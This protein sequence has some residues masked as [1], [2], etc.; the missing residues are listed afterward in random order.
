MEVSAQDVSSLRKK[1]GAGIMDCKES[2][3]EAGG[4]FEQAI[5]FLRKKGKKVSVDRF[6][7]DT[8]EGAVFACVNED[9]TESFLVVLSCETDFVAKNSLFLQLGTAILQI[10]ATHKPA[11][12]DELQVLSLGN[13]TVQEDIISSMGTVG[14]KISVSSYEILKGEVV[15]S[16]IHSGNRLGVLVALKGAN[17]ENVLAAGR[18]VAM[19][20]AAM[21]PVALDK[22][23]MDKGVIEREITFIKEKVMAEGHSEDKVDKI[24]QGRLSKFFQENTLLEQLFVKNN[25]LTM[26]QY[27]KK[28]SPSLTVT[29]F[30]RI[31]V[32]E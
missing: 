19:H 1:T 13:G 4:D 14:E 2:L 29:S 23:Q 6:A 31:S 8:S 5:R 32:N 15:I 22:N 17:G 16:Y 24:T 10:A 18:D 26:A 20:I 30:K 25:K 11:S 27:L 3:I 9:H 21:N 12:I 28:I 7:R